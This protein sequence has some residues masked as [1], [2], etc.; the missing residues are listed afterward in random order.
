MGTIF[1]L[2]SRYLTLENHISG[3][4]KVLDF[5]KTDLLYW[6]HT[7]TFRPQLKKI[8]DYDF[9]AWYLRLQ[10]YSKTFRQS[11]ISCCTQKIY[12][13]S[14]FFARFRWNF[15]SVVGKSVCW[16]RSNRSFWAKLMFSCQYPDFFKKI[17]FFI[18]L[19]WLKNL[20]SLNQG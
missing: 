19:K 13:K 5:W 18:P 17:E 11:V 12:R 14:A 2:R 6:G 9:F 20:Y 15:F 10:I 1:S 3:Y 8:W 16:I 4:E 7:V